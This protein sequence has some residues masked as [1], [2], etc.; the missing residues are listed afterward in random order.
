MRV[1][2]TGATGFI[3]RRLCQSL[4]GQGSEVTAFSRDPG[5]ARERLPQAVKL[6][7]W[8]P[9]G[10][11]PPTEALDGLDAVVSLAGESI[12]GGRWTDHQ[13]RQIRESRTIG[14]RNLVAGLANTPSRPRLLVSGSAIGYYGDR[15][16]EL[17]D[18][19]STP[20]T[21]FLGG[22]C[23]EWESEANRAQ[24]LGIRIAIVRT[25]LVLGPGGGVLAPLLP[26]FRSGLGG[27]LGSGR[28]WMSWIHVDDEV[29]LIQWLLDR[30]LADRSNTDFPSGTGP[31]PGPINATAPEPATNASFTRELARVLGRP[32][33]F[34]VP[35]IALK[36]A[37]GES[38]TLLLGSQRVY[39]RVAL[40]G[41]YNY[42]FPDLRSALAASINT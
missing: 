19:S 28:Q 6:V 3:G 13:K 38:S 4:T 18:E 25:G 39:P 14:T 26:L 8:N 29:G 9:L 32:S 23:V 34:V 1:G 35:G 5:R 16:N 42:Q 15:G 12:S 30:E 7:A 36:L 27:T 41:G 31:H 20:G 37:L 10:G 33:L 11:P 22:V 40:A 2:V 17:L 21:D 24:A